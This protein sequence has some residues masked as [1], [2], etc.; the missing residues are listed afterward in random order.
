LLV[1]WKIGGRCGVQ[2][3]QL[4]LRLISKCRWVHCRW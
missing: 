2:G 3:I 4:G 1:W